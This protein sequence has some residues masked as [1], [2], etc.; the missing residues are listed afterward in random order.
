M[1]M[2][3]RGGPGKKV[4]Q[5]RQMDLGVRRYGAGKSWPSTILT[6]HR[7]LV[8]EYAKL[9]GQWLAPPGD[10]LPTSQS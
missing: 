3:V 4:K 2:T 8:L 6:V 1:P 9:G 10:M 7:C 5:A